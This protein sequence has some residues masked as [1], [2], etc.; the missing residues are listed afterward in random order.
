MSDNTIRIEITLP[1]WLIALLTGSTAPGPVATPPE[2]SARDWLTDERVET[3]RA[4]IASG[5]QWRTAL[6][7]LKL[8]PEQ[9]PS[10]AGFRS[11]MRK[12]GLRIPRSPAR[13]AGDAIRVAAMQLA[14]NSKRRPVAPEPPA[15]P[16]APRPVPTTPPA[17]RSAVAGLSAAQL[18]QLAQLAGRTTPHP[19]PVMATLETIINWAGAR[20][21]AVIGKDLAAVNKKR[22]DLQL[23]PFEIETRA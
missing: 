16:P 1:D 19:W 6:A 13:A 14:K 12:L 2:P 5:K 18:A 15:E 8:P 7:M 3:V 4:A 21:I 9:A 20:G 23:P 10:V 11:R 17:A 22:R